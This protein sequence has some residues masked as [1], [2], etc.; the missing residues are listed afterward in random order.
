[1]TWPFEKETINALL[2]LGAV[3]V[4]TLIILVLIAAGAI[5]TPKLVTT[6]AAVSRIETAVGNVRQI[7]EGATR[8][9]TAINGALGGAAADREQIKKL[10]EQMDRRDREMIQAHT[11]QIRLLRLVCKGVLPTERQRDRC[12]A[13]VGTAYERNDY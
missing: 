12:N 2:K 13:P 5:Y 1:M 4:L 9:E 8:I 6:D 10:L 3:G 7:S 11:E